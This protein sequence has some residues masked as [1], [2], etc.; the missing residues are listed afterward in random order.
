MNT[1][2]L[3]LIIAVIASIVAFL[4]GS[5][6]NVALPAI[7]HD[8]NAGFASQQWVVDAYLLT[9]G[10]FILIAGSLSDILG[11]KRV[12]MI[13]LV[14]FGV[15]SILCALALSDEMLIIARLL[16][17]IG[18]ALLVPSSLA[19]I[20][21]A[22]PKKM[23]SKTIGQWTAWTGI[24]LLA[25]PILGGVLVDYASWRWVFLI[26]ILPIALTIALLAKLKL[27]ES[28]DQRAKVDIIGATLGIIGLGGTVF[29]L[30][31]QPHLGLAHPLI[32]ST[33]LI[34]V[35]S[36]VA[37]MFYE[38]R[39]THPMMP[40]DLFR[41]RNFS[42]GNLATFAIYAGLAV[43]SFIIS[44]FVQQV[45]GYSATAAGFALI[46]VTVIMFLL[47]ARFGGL[48]EKYGP[49][50]FMA[51]GPIIAGIGFLT[52]LAVGADA[53]YLVLLPGIILFGIGLATTVA[54]LTSAVLMAISSRQSGIASAI[55]NAVARI[56]GLIAI[57]IIGIIVGQNLDLI[58]F[59]RTIFFTAMLMI[60]G[61]VISALGIT[62]SKPSTSS[63]AQAVAS[64]S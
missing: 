15:S 57:A 35:I 14:W 7:A 52:M 53:N 17:G 18:G 38:K 3:V 36:L 48:A 37:F 62:N 32:V 50:L 61:G 12:M 20:I 55:N 31:E 28:S 1:T 46:P 2:R 58:G 59:H 9:L 26:N 60:A 27:D 11:H 23:Q 19:L 47:S 51:L 10:A 64:E 29:A 30:I 42:V 44:I 25:G 4:D 5:I 39:S 34:G 43:A 16:Q 13:G 8:F 63:D 56:A 22:V 45:G 21:T 49:R 41:V 24:A 33:F 40:L 6:V 54:P